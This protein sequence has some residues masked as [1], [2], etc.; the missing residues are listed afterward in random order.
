[1]TP[2][3]RGAP[4]A[5]VCVDVQYDFIGG[6]LGGSGRGNVVGPLARISRD[7]E[8]AQVTVASRDL[9]PPGHCSFAD[10]EPEFRDG[11]WPAHCVAGTPGAQLAAPIAKLAD[12]VVDKGQDRDREA[13]SAFE[14]WVA[15]GQLRMSTDGL[16]RGLGVRRLVVGGLCTDHCVL[17]TVFDA[18]AF[19]YEVTVPLDACAGVDAGASRDAVGAMREV[20]ARVVDTLAG[21]GRA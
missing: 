21:G 2:V 15:F 16:L 20:G 6:S 18:R 4:R 1:M 13:Y 3:R 8:L 5:L 12:V 10:G 14:G 19:G 9:H 11:S 7:P 17:A